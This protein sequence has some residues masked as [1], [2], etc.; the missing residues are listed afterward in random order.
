[1]TAT[2]LAALA[3]DQG[4]FAVL[5][6]DQRGTLRRMLDAAGRPST[7]ADLKAFKVDVVSALAPLSSGVLLDNDFGVPAVREAGA[8]P[9]GVGLLIAAEPTEKAT[10]NGEYRT[11]TDPERDA[12]WVRANGGDGL[13]FLV[14]WQPDRPAVPGEPDL[15][16]EAMDTVAQVVKDCRETGVPSIIEP[17]VSFAPSLNP[18]Q[19]EKHEAVIL[20]A[21]RLATLEPS[22]LKLEWPGGAEGCR[23]VSDALGEVPWALLSAGV[24]YEDFVERCRIALDN[25]ASGIIAGRAIWK[26]AVDLEGEERRAFLREVS[27]PRLAGLVDVLRQHG[28]SWEDVAGVAS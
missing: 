27:V 13:K 6:M 1:M 4:R 10:W 2:G 7:T 20:S 21:A 9:P 8:L 3:D 11:V 5:A 26:E 28:R 12:A 17:L 23:R 16:G 19:E 25:G 22:L 18:T 14:Y 24:G 15:A